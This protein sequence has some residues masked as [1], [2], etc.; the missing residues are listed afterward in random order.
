MHPRLKEIEGYIADL[1]ANVRLCSCPKRVKLRS[2]SAQLGGLLCSHEQTSPVRAVVR[3]VPRAEVVA[4]RNNSSSTYHAPAGASVGRSRSPCQFL[5]E[6]PVV[7]FSNTSPT[8]KLAALARGGNS[9]KLSMYFAT[10]AC[11]GTNRKTRCANQSPY[12]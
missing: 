5:P 4:G 8:V 2:L 1:W 11:A 9:L 12:D 10:M 7:S 6:L 3:K